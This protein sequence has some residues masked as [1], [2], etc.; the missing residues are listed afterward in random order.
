MH[1]AGLEPTVKENHRISTWEL[2]ACPSEDSAERW[3]FQFW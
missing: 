1:E 2:A 3:L